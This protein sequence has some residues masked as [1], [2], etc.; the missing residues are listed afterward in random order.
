MRPPRPTRYRATT[1]ARTRRA[2]L[3]SPTA[4]TVSRLLRARRATT[5]AA[6]NVISGNAGSGL[7]I[8]GAANFVYGNFVGVDVTGNKALANVVG[9]NVEGTG[10]VIGGALAGQGNVI[11]GNVS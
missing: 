6:R 7:F 4:S 10:N 1:S 11:S 5:A 8:S 9:V 2:R 3:P